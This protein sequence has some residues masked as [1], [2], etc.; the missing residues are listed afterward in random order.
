MTSRAPAWLH[1]V[2]VVVKDATA[3]AQHPDL[4]DG[5]AATPSDLG[6]PAS[7]VLTTEAA[8]AAIDGRVAAGVA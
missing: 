5:Y 4:G 7:G 6:Y 8:V 2:G 1:S 3:V